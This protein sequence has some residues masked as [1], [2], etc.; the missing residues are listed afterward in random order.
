MDAN[1]VGK[2][3]LLDY[4]GISLHEKV[5]INKAQFQIV[6]QFSISVY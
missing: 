6:Y 2:R 4:S 3:F 1:S 5:L